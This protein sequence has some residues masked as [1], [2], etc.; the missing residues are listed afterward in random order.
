MTEKTEFIFDSNVPNDEIDIYGKPN[1]QIKKLSGQVPQEFRIEITGLSVD[2]SIVNGLRRTIMADIP[3]YAFHRSNIFIDIKKSKN[4]YNN[5]LIY[6]QLETLPIFDVPNFYDLEDP[7]LYLSSEVLKRL[8]SK[9]IQEKYT[10]EM[11]TVEI[12]ENKKLFKI[13]LFLNVKNHDNVDKFVSTHD[14]I[15]KI[16]GKTVD[17]YKN[18]R[19]LSILV[20]KPNEEIS[21]RAEANLGIAKMNGSYEATT[22]VIF[23]QINETTYHLWYETLGQLDNETIFKKANVILIKK[24]ENLKQY[25]QQSYPNDIDASEKVKLQLYGEDHTLGN[26]LATVLQKCQFVEKAGYNMPHPFVE[27]VNVEYQLYPDYKKGPIKIFVDCVN[28]LITV[29]QTILKQA[30][31]L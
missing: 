5:D 28:Y 21:L 8:F 14:C 24:L 31:K 10:N 18:R 19:P 23:D 26:L 17:S 30:E 29:Y 3:I 1:V 12:D 27:S 22:N 15:L 20:L 4:M 16:D 6:N 2:N 9:F 13:E 11:T 25:I 7:E